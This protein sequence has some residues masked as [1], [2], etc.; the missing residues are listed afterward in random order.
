MKLSGEITRTGVL[1]QKSMHAMKVNGSFSG[2]NVC[3][4]QFSCLFISYLSKYV[5]VEANIQ[6]TPLE[7]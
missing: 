2:G 5:I 6:T 3:L 1:L 4:F 7:K